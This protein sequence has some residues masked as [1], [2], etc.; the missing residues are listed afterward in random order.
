[1]LNKYNIF[2]STSESLKTLKFGFYFMQRNELPVVYQIDFCWQSSKNN[3]LIDKKSARILLKILL[4]AW[5]KSIIKSGAPHHSKLSV[6]FARNCEEKVTQIAN[7]YDKQKL[8][9]RF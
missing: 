9:W 4:M 2:V 8:V 3:L 5:L 1:M 6:N 7:N